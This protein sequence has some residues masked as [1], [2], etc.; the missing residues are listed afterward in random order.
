MSKDSRYSAQLRVLSATKT[1]LI[2]AKAGVELETGKQIPLAEFADKVINDALDAKE[3]AKLSVNNH[4][5][6]PF[7]AP[8]YRCPDKLE[9][10]GICN[11]PFSTLGGL[12]IHRGHVH[13]IG[14]AESP[15]AKSGRQDTPK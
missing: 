3:I 8:A 7:G 5:G 1:R 10:G 13:K 2:R 15:T 12:N 6:D 11:K 9:G 14:I 4:A